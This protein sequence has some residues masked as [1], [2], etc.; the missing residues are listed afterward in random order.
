MTPYEEIRVPVAGGRLAA[1]RWP[2]GEPGAP[3]VVALHGITANALSWGTVA[4]ML[5]G[6]VTLI[7]PD[8]R[9]RAASAGLPGPYGIAA[10]ADD[11]AA[12]SEGLG[13]DRVVLA[14]HS[15]GAFVA[16]LAAVRHPDR[17]G[18]LLLVDGGV[19]F[20]A[21]THL[22]PDELMTAV[23]GPA[24]DRLSM[25]FADRA[26][27]RAFWQAHPAF[28]GD[29][30]SPEVDAYIQ[31]DLTGEEPAMHSTC[32]IEAVRTDGIGLFDDEVLSA[33]RK[34]P[35]PATLLWAARGLMDEE[36]G[37]YDEKR[38]AA[39]GLGDTRVEPVAVPDVN[40]YTV[41]TGGSGAREVAARLAALANTPVPDNA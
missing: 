8:L 13:L 34:L 14:G 21:P 16:A 17:F 15:M 1:L 28:A 40:H 36:Q 26:A 7:A 24:M 35:V 32:R 6:R 9:G 3:V 20:P 31:R 22:S 38:L 39:A 29:A 12:L 4:R 25:T 37:L 33:V 27:Y 10:H 2:A 5:A 18:P 30:W 19:G 41:L 23:I 11:V